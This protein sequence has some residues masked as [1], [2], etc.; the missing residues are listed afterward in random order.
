M[1]INKAIV[2]NIV[3]ILSLIVMMVTVYNIISLENTAN[4]YSAWLDDV[5]NKVNQDTSQGKQ[6]PDDAVVTLIKM[7]N[8]AMAKISNESK[9][10]VFI[11]IFMLGLFIS[12]ITYSWV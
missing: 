2:V 4:K 3:V 5:L 6:F 10:N 1:S 8:T 11:F 9:L 12:T 7:H